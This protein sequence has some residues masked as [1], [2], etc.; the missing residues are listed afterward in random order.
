VQEEAGLDHAAPFPGRMYVCKQ[1]QSKH[2]ADQGKV[3]CLTAG[4]LL[5]FCCY[6]CGMWPG[7]RV[8]EQTRCDGDVLVSPTTTPG[9]SQSDSWQIDGE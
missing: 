3:S 8:A 7:A 1:T 4:R 5:D 9:Q 2:S 6:C